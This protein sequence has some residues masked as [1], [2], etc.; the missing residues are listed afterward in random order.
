MSPQSEFA[1]N[2][3][4][5]QHIFKMENNLYTPEFSS[6]CAKAA[7][8][9]GRYF[10]KIDGSNH[11]VMKHASGA[12]SLYARYDVKST[13]RIP[14]TCMELPAGGNP[15]RYTSN[16]KEHHYCYRPV[17]NVTG[18]MANMY[19]RLLRAAQSRFAHEPPGHYSVEVV[20]RKFQRTPGVDADAA[21]AVHADQELTDV[22][23]ST[24]ADARTYLLDTVCAEGIIV[25]HA[26]VY[27]KL[28]SNCFDKECS[29]DGIKGSSDLPANFVHAVTVS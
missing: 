28:R 15:A 5:M 17:E 27:W 22:R 29:F 1:F 11:M 19:G 13:E 24:Y 21:L 26:G 7:L 3:G 12:L 10:V 14:N 2:G 9:C 16:H 8:L 25:E 6:E 20:G 23:L 18:K 4:K